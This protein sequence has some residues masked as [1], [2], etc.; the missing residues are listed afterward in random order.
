[1]ESFTGL[2]S[3]LSDTL[4]VNFLPIAIVLVL[5]LCVV[6]WLVYRSM[7][8]SPKVD[9]N[10]V[11]E[12]HETPEQFSEDRSETSETSDTENEQN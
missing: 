6:G 7:V 10:F 2:F 9:E 11:D 3:N 8:S 12:V 4:T 1:M 5:V